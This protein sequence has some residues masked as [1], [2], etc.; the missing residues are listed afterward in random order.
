MSFTDLSGRRVLLTGAAGG[1]GTAA[2]ETLV[3]AGAT[4]L[5][6]DNDPQK[7]ALL[8]KSDVIV[9]IQ[10]DLRDPQ[11]LRDMVA[12]QTVNAPIWGL[13]NNAAIY[14]SKAI[15]DY[16]VE[17]LRAV[18]QVNIEA[19][20]VLVQSLI[21]SFKVEG[22]GRVVSISSNTWHGGWE[23]LSPYVIT[24]AGLIG[25]T[26]SFAREL[27]QYGVNVNAIAPGA[28]QT[29]AEKIH[30]D[31]EAY[32]RFIVEHQSLKRRGQ[33]TE[34]ASV[35]LFLLSDMSSFISG[36]TINVDGGWFMV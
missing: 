5:A 21:P 22:R 36:Q 16:S 29:E 14:P 25:L 10:A 31:P 12:E 13:V 2:C 17:E 27:G 4:V 9:P 33:P 11:A 18:E 28:F 8:P 24:K 32:S 15:E 6:L 19:A 26:R 30:A 3:A 35:L 1:L 7:L 34:F 20:F 23:R